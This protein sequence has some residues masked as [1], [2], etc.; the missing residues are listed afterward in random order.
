MWTKWLAQGHNTLAPIITHKGRNWLW[1]SYYTF[2]FPKS[3][4][5]R[6]WRA[7]T[8]PCPWSWGRSP[9]CPGSGLRY[10]GGREVGGF[11]SRWLKKKT[12]FSR[13]L[14]DLLMDMATMTGCQPE[15]RTSLVWGFC[16]ATSTQRGISAKKNRHTR[17]GRYHISE[18]G[19]KRQRTVRPL[20]DKAGRCTGRHKKHV[21]SHPGLCCDPG[22]GCELDTWQTHFYFSLSFLLNN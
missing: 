20:Q 3:M 14:T 19:E 7:W 15:R 12:R 6:W 13:T 10:C 18:W 8:R 9:S 17:G 16:R 2:S 22:S 4:S 5:Y 1:S 11:T 21:M